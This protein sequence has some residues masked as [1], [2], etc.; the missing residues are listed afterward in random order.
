MGMTDISTQSQIGG[1]KR[2]GELDNGP[3]RNLAIG[4]G[5]DRRLRPGVWKVYTRKKTKVAKEDGMDEK[6]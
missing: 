3:N 6:E 4:V 5:L 2:M 1:V